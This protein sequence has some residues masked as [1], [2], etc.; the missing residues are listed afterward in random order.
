[1]RIYRYIYY[2][3]Y[4][5][6]LR[7]HGA[8]DMPQYNAMIGLSAAALMNTLTIVLIVTRLLG[9]AE[10]FVALGKPMGIVG[11]GVSMLLHYLYLVSGSQ[12]KKIKKEFAHTKPEMSYVVGY[13]VVTFAAFFLTGYLTLW[14]THS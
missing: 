5:W 12:L 1:M 10:R 9:L 11:M 6:G 3:L 14:P 2:S 4:E 13:G 7:K 8:V